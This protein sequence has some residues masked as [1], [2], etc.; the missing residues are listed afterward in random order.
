[1]I[2]IIIIII[3]LLTGGGG[4]P[5][6]LLVMLFS[7]PVSET[8]LARTALIGG[9]LVCLGRPEVFGPEGILKKKIERI[10][11]FVSKVIIYRLDNAS[12]FLRDLNYRGNKFN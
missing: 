4:Q 1:M 6:M 8:R 10:W 7:A 3:I 11:K 12:R 9:V 2:I 5:V